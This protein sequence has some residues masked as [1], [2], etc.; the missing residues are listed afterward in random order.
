MDLGFPGRFQR[1]LTRCEE[2]EAVP[3]LWTE[4]GANADEKTT[5]E[6]TTAT[7]VGDDE[8]E[9]KRSAATGCGRNNNQTIKRKKEKSIPVL[10]QGQEQAH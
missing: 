5:S 4:C 8:N 6:T 3:V 2:L 9:S 7:T 1:Y 10:F